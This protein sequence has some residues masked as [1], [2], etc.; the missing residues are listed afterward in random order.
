MMSTIYYQ[1]F[2]GQLTSKEL[3]TLNSGGFLLGSDSKAGA[4]PEFEGKEGKDDDGEEHGPE[5]KTAPP[6]DITA[7]EEYCSRNTTQFPKNFY[8][9]QRTTDY[10]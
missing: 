2:I 7:L 10:L 1:P 6:F 9:D 5:N 4:E 3:T 8:M